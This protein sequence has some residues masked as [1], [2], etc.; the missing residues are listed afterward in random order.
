[1]TLNAAAVRI[2]ITGELYSAPTGTARPTTSTD[3]LNAAYTGLGYISEDG[4]TEEPDDNVERI[5]AW[6]NATVVRA[7][8][9]ESTTTLQCTLI[10]TKG[11][12][13]EAYHKGSTVEVVSAGQWKIDVKAPTEDRRQ[14]VLDVIDGTK[15]LRFDVPDGEILDRGAIVYA[16]GEAVGYEITITCYPDANN[17][18]YTKYSDDANWGYS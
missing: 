11:A 12:V 5:V 8:T 9:T 3:V 17:V 2:G 16:N 7:N 14:W 1:M 15:H 18:L 6:Q 10:E 4:V 13:L